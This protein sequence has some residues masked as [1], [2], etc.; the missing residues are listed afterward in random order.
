MVHSVYAEDTKIVTED[1]I[2]SHILQ[3]KSEMSTHFDLTQLIVDV[4]ISRRLCIT[5]DWNHLP[6]VHYMWCVAH[7]NKTTVLNVK[8]SAQ[9]Q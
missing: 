9:V 5:G 7:P 3:K 2:H 6:T 4:V 8:R 1:W